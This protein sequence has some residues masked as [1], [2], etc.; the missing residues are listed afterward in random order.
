MF[1]IVEGID[2]S[3]K[4]SAVES[5]NVYLANKDLKFKTFKPYNNSARHQR[6]IKLCKESNLPPNAMVCIFITLMSEVLKNDIIPAILEGNI[7]IVDRWIYSTIVYQHCAMGVSDKFI[8]NLIDENLAT[9]QHLD[10]N[11]PHITKKYRDN[12]KDIIDN[13]FVIYMNIENRKIIEDRISKRDVLENN[14][15]DRLVSTV[16]FN[17][18][19]KGYKKIFENTNVFYVN[20]EEDQYVVNENIVDKLDSL[21]L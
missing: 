16:Y 13:P 9:K 4:T 15:L 18:I 6:L 19:I 5:I 7:V 1:I 3:G 2:G 21:N 10:I 12:I 17:N 14:R 11:F 20:A 8:S